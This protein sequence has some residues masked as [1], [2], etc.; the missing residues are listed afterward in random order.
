MSNSLSA[1]NGPAGEADFS[2]SRVRIRAAGVDD[3]PAMCRLSRE[4]GW[5]HR[6]DDWLLMLDLADALVLENSSGVIG[7]GLRIVQGDSAS[8]ALILVKQ[9]CR[10]M[11]LGKRLMAELVNQS[12]TSS[13]F[14]NATEE[15]VPLYR[16]YGFCDVGTVSQWQGICRPKVQDSLSDRTEPLIS[17]DSD[18]VRQMLYQARG[19]EPGTLIS[20]IN[21]TQ[22]RLICLRDNNLLKGFAGLRRFGRGWVIGPVIAPSSQ[23]AVCLIESLAAGL[24]GEFLRVDQPKS[25]G[26]DQCLAGL[27]L[28]QVDQVKQMWRTEVPSLTGE[29]RLYALFSQA[30]G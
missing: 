10:G 17:A 3:L 30:T 23:D 16:K 22:S 21:R 6:E 7:C 15:G 25:A 18:E 27:G 13:L 26:L 24:D 4:Q 29:Q 8:L 28:R 14:L 12:P 5:P 20:A 11:G 2:P 19:M 9:D 1:K